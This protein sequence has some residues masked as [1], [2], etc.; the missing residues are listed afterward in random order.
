VPL[1][2][3]GAMMSSEVGLVGYSGSCRQCSVE[4][5]EQKHYS[6]G[7]CQMHYIRLKRHGS[8][9]VCI[10]NQDRRNVRLSEKKVIEIR[11][12]REA[13]LTQEAVAKHFGIDRTTVSKVDCGINW[14]GAGL[15]RADK[16][17]KASGR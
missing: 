14:V 1:A 6:R 4:G 17:G 3:G 16:A 2:S 13:G 7:L 8:P 5:C 10:S 12:M 15:G 11:K 9:L